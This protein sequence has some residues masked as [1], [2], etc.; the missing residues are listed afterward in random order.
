M[1][2]PEGHGPRIFRWKIRKINF[3]AWIGCRDWKVVIERGAF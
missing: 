1:Q 3:T 2:E